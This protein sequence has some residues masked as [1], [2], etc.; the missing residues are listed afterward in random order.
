M[1]RIAVLSYF[2][3]F[4]VVGCA[5]SPRVSTWESPERFTKEVVFKAAHQAGTQNGWEVAG[6]DREAGTMSFLQRFGKEQMAFNVL[7]LEQG[8]RIVVRTTANWGGGL[9]IAGHHEEFI[10]N[11]HV[12]LFRNL[13]ISGASER[14][15]KIEEL[16]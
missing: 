14:N 12:L 2:L 13:N 11:F 1:R 15:V 7:I 16:R 4:F 6:F 10:H 9:A 5:F 8:G 3:M